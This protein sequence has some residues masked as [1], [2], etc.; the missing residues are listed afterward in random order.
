MEGG[1]RA[2]KSPASRDAA[3]ERALVRSRELTRCYIY[4]AISYESASMAAATSTD[5][6]GGK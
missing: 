4:D 2:N 6:A 3:M 5:I 1:Q